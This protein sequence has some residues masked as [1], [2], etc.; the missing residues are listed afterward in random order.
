MIVLETDVLDSMRAHAREAYPEECCGVLLGEV[1]G[2]ERRVRR[3]A[4]MPNARQE[5][6]RRRF[7]IT[8]EDYRAA[9]R[10][11]ERR[12]L[13]LIGFYHSH[14]DHPARPSQYDLDHALPWHSYVIVAVA[15]GR[16]EECTSWVLSADRARF[17]PEEMRS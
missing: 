4:A 11:A 14:P 9:E 12:G 6:R 10:D 5:E 15:K 8:P 17:E 1:G 7:L 3:A 16:A 13:A 2:S